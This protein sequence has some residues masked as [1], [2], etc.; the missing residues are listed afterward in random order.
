MASQMLVS[1]LRYISHL[2]GSKDSEEQSDSQLLQRFVAHRDEGTFIALLQRH[3]PLVF[4]ICKQVLRDAHDADDAF[5]ATFLVLARKAA[6]IRQHES[7][8]AW[9]HRVAL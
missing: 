7:L 9:L 3:G 5:Q 4:G 2:S 1:V 8:A 6:L